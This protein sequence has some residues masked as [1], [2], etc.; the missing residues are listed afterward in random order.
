MTLPL[1]VALPDTPDEFTDPEFDHLEEA[2]EA[3]QDV[4]TSGRLDFTTAVQVAQA[5]ALISI[6]ESLDVLA[7]TSELDADEVAL[8]VVNVG[9]LN[10]RDNSAPEPAPF[11][12]PLDYFREG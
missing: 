6:A 3:L 11:V 8:S 10:V 5:H 7:F 2:K 1:P 4:V 9:E 12:R